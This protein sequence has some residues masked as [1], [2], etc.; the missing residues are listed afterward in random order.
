MK[1]TD[2]QVRNA[3]SAGRKQRKLFDGGGLH[4]MLTDKGGKYWRFRY[5][6]RGR[7]C[8]LSLGTYPQI[9]LKQV[10]QLHRD[11]QTLLHQGIDPHA[12]KMRQR[13]EARQA[14][15]QTASFAHFAR[16][17]YEGRKNSYT[18]AKAAQQVINTLQQYAFPLIG[19]R[20]ITELTTADITAVLAPLIATKPETASRLKQRIS[21]VFDYAVQMGCISHNPVLSTPKIIRSGDK[22]VKNHP[23]LPVARLGEFF[24]RLAQ[25]PN[26]KTALALRL[27]ILTLTR[28]GELRHGQWQELSGDQW[29]IPAERMKMK[30]PHIVP[31]S[32]WALA[33]LDELRALNRYNSPYFV[34]GNRNQPLSDMTLS[35]A[36]KRMGYT[37]I[38]VPHGFRAMASTI[39]NESGRWNPDAIERQLAHAGG[40]AIR[41]AYNRAEYLDERRKMMQ[42]YADYIRQQTVG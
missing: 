39:L 8:L 12:Q 25:Y 6:F 2:R 28:S 31:L 32:D 1:L 14:A 22:R 41:A 5:R 7:D 21:G 38:A 40:N 3:D 16:Q 17:W 24:A 19:E 30:R 20:A 4:L 15:R 11:A 34:T 23:A 10:R 37:G 35:A 18:N 33:T 29:H 27:L 36:M 9:S 13:R 42:W 26:T